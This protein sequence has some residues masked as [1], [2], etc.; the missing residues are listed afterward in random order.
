VK[1]AAKG[2]SCATASGCDCREWVSPVRARGPPLRRRLKAAGGSDPAHCSTRAAGAAVFAARFVQH[3]GI[4]QAGV[5]RQ[6]AATQHCR[7]EST[8][9]PCTVHGGDRAV[10]LQ[11]AWRRHPFGTARTRTAQRCKAGP[12]SRLVLRPRPRP[13][14]SLDRS[15]KLHP[16]WPPACRQRRQLRQPGLRRQQRPHQAGG[17]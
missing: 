3:G 14:A 2:R 11:L 15:L 17:A 10:T 6:T 13:L 4:A 5:P 12:A 7:L 1:A 8:A 16:P 9:P